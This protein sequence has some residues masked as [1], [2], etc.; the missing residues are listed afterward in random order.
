MPVLHSDACI[1]D[2]TD[3]AEVDFPTIKWIHISLLFDFHSLFILY[4]LNRITVVVF[5]T[6]ISFVYFIIASGTKAQDVDAKKKISEFVL[7]L[8]CIN[9]I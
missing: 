5:C 4:L 8:T 1:Y 6:I 3:F 9:V 7:L 2:G